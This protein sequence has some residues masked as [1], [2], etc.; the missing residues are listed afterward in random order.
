M[1]NYI[2]ST[3]DDTLMGGPSNDTIVGGA[4]NDTLS[5]G[6]GD[7]VLDG[8]TGNHLLFSPEIGFNGSTGNASLGGGEAVAALANGGFVVVRTD[9]TAQR[10]DANGSAVGGQINVQET[11][12]SGVTN[13]LAS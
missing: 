11:V 5:G 4:G 6:P 8:G 9:A 13:S 7:D 10:Y 1:T 3:A 2:G 12:S